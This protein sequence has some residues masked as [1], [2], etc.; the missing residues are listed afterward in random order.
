MRNRT[1]TLLISFAVLL[2]IVNPTIGTITILSYMFI[3]NKKENAIWA[4]VVLLLYIWCFQSTRSFSI[5]EP[6]DW[7]NYCV[8]FN[9]VS[10]LSFTDYVFER[11][12]EYVWQI[13]NIIG[14]YIF[15]GDFLHF[16]FVIVVLTYAFTFLAIYYYWKGSNRDFRTLL[17][18]LILIAFFSEFL[19]ILNNLLRQQFAFSMMLFVLVRRLVSKKINW[20]LLIISLFTH[21]MIAL[22]IPFLFFNINRKF[23]FKQY[24]WIVVCFCIL[25]ILFNNLHI[26]SSF[27]FFVFQKLSNSYNHSLNDVIDSKV[28]YPFLAVMLVFYIKAFFIDKRCEENRL[29]FN[30]L[31]IILL[32][33]CLLMTPMPLIQT[34]YYIIRLFIMPFILPY[35]FCSK[36]LGM[37]Y[38]SCV[39]LFFMIRFLSYDYFW[40]N[41]DNVLDRSLFQFNLLGL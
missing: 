40:F 34:R 39:C 8:N 11:G 37:A 30:N 21:I 23:S 18:G 10:D 16:A 13:I 4:M 28:I 36:L 2:Y 9:Q 25:N 7:A 41:T 14:Y 20:W 26:F 33:L 3:V 29:S 1:I 6:M 32:G 17:T 15:K 19:E 35:F 12:R 27:S 38:Q 31:M 22:F 5:S 24:S